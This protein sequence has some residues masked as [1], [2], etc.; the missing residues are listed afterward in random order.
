[1]RADTRRLFTIVTRVKRATHLAARDQPAYAR[2]VSIDHCYFSWRLTTLLVPASLSVCAC[3]VQ[4]LALKQTADLLQQAEPVFERETDLEL[5]AQALPTNIKMVEG[6]LESS[7]QNEKLLNAAARL[8]SSYATL[9]V[10]QRLAALEE[11]SEQADRQRQRAKEMHLRSHQYSLRVLDLKYPGF[12]AAFKQ[13]GAALKAGL[14]RIASP[15]DALP[16]VRAALALGSA[17]AI[18]S[19]DVALLGLLYKAKAMARRAIAID[20]SLDHGAAHLVL[21]SLYGA[22]GK[23]FGGD[24]DKSERHFERA[25]T[26]TK[27]RFLMVQVLYATTWA[28]QAQKE[29]RFVELLQEVT[30]AKLEI[31]PTQKL[32]NVLA[33]SKA[34]RWLAKRS[35]LF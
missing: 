25:L 35:E 6:L 13:G 1:M 29:A 12:S 20:E 26:L 23:S 8:Y 22:V 21:G 16:L 2:N 4:Q 11:D 30:R 32:A 10:E 33:K 7:P 14:N 9:A 31:Y 24:L 3:S 34:K 28:I 17:I 15:D 18:A 27:R 19:D 5:V